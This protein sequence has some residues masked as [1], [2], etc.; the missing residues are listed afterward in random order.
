M[1]EEEK[2]WWTERLSKAQSGLYTPPA[3]TETIQIPSVT[4]GAAF[5]Q[6][7]GLADHP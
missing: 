7:N 1:T 2:K 5:I 6:N 4:G 3:L